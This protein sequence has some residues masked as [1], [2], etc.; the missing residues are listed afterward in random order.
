MIYDATRSPDPAAW[1]AAD[2]GERL[3]A[4]L[5]H[6]G[7]LAA[8][9]R[10]PQPRLHA[11]LHLVVESQLALGKPPEAGRALARLIRGGLDRHEAVHAIAMLVSN[12]AAAAMEGGR[13][14]AGAYGRE[15]D[16]LT[17]ERWKAL[18]AGEG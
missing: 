12:V 14:D 2:E 1:L 8:H 4:V 3:E 16:A 5:A 7:A 11:A 15:L 9:P 6:H 10:M 17:V 18:G 13:Y